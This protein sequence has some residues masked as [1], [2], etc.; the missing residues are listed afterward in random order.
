MLNT[1]IN[2]FTLKNRIIVTVCVLSN[3][4]LNVSF[5]YDILCVCDLNGNA[6][7]KKAFYLLV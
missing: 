5:S 6:T 4:C 3:L 2:Q 7:R 1:Q